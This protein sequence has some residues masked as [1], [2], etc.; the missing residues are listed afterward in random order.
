[1]SHFYLTLISN[2]SQSF[3]PD[4][5]L[6]VFKTKLHENVSLSGDWE[7]GLV[8]LQFPKNWHNIGENE[9]ME[10]GYVIDKKMYK[11]RVDIKPGYYSSIEELLEELNARTATVLGNFVMGEPTL[12]QR[13]IPVF[14]YD[15]LLCKVNVKLSN[16]CSIT[17]TENLSST[18]GS[19]STRTISNTLTRPNIHQI[20]HT[21]DVENGI[22]SFFIYCDI[23]EAV[24]VAGTVSPLLR[25]CDGQGTHGTQVHRYYEKPRYIPIQKKDFDTIGIDIRTNFGAV[26][27]FQSG[28]GS[29]VLT[30]HFRKAKENYFV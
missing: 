27:P 10:I 29:V 12:E 20:E 6:S 28:S 23:L 30:L 26:V 9:S 8:E 3:Y 5:T 14:F 11:R 16:E 15:H 18:L 7:C 4:N 24:P 2:D 22:R 25:I 21:S 19:H 1:M 17:F 13:R